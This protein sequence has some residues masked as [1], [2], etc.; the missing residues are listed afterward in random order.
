M[1]PEKRLLKAMELSQ[2][3]RQLFFEGLRNSF[4]ELSGKELK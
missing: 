1:T 4:P 2:L 3:T